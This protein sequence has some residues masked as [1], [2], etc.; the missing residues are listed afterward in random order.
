MDERD[1]AKVEAV[2]SSPMTATTLPWCN[3]EHGGVLSRQGA[4]SNLAGSTDEMPT[5]ITFTLKIE[6]EF[7]MSPDD[8]EHWYGQTAQSLAADAVENPC[9]DEIPNLVK[10]KVVGYKQCD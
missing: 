9:D 8:I 6:A 10:F 7:V 2:G 3:G 5:T 4:S 1:P